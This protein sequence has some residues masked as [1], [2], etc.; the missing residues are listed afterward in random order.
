MIK[1]FND[2]LYDVE[3]Y[4]GLERDLGGEESINYLIGK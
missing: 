4:T 2:H 1:F 3:Y